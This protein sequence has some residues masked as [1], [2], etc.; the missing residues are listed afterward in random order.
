M[1]HLCKQH[2]VSSVPSNLVQLPSLQFDGANVLRPEA[3]SSLSQQL[4]DLERRTGYHVRVFT[5][6]D[7]DATDKGPSYRKAWGLDK[8]TVVIRVDPSSPNIIGV[9][10]IGD[11]VLA[12]LRRG[13]WIELQSRFGNIFTVRE[14]GDAAAVLGAMSAV[15]ECLGR[16]QGC[17]VVPGLVPE[18]YYATLA[19]SV[20]G[21]LVAGFVSRIE[22]QGFV[23]RR[24]VWLLLF[25]PLWGSLFVSFGLGPVVSRTSDLAP[26][27]GNAAAFLGAAVTPGLLQRLW[28][29]SEPA[30]DSIN[31]D[32]Q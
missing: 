13:F 6:Y 31:S 21:G 7:V 27:A 5:Q 19:C 8:N 12:K 16:D 20:A 30:N 24:W 15:T 28:A 11:N 9:P 14:Q 1:W 18:E 22:P 17:A 25:S 26:I 10:Y 29:G 2:P 4:V 23:Q 32:K 3:R